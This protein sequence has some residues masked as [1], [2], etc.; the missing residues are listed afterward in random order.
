MGKNKLR[1][2]LWAA[3]ATFLVWDLSQWGT[4]E[5]PIRHAGVDFLGYFASAR[6]L[7]GGGNPYDPAVMLRAE[8][9]LGYSDAKALV[10]WAPPWS[11]LLLLPFTLFPFEAARVAWFCCNAALL[12]WVAWQYWKIVSPIRPGWWVALPVFL[13]V[14]SALALNIGQVSPVVLV[15]LFGFARCAESRRDFL[16]GVF[17]VLPTI[18]PHPVYLF[19][20]FLPFWIAATRRWRVLSGLAI[21]LAASILVVTFLSPGVFV[22]YI[23]GIASEYGAKAWETPTIPTL[24]RVAFPR[25]GEILMYVPAAAG[26]ALGLVVW[27]RRRA[28]FQW[29]DAMIPVT[30][31]STITAPYGWTMDLVVLLP[32]VLVILAK[33]AASPRCLWLPFSALAAMQIVMLVQIYTAQSY[34]S[35]VWVAPAMAAVYWLATRTR[36]SRTAAA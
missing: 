5:K 29:L 12:V 25:G 19:W 33:F 1:I 4:A 16:A 14:P 15:G 17:A 31:L 22:A 18:K 21:P 35:L 11:H 34:F 28:D 3:I 30:L 24:L 8:R 23:E 32:V 2:L 13:F 26:C 7:A 27:F 9:E 10:V 20:L 6:T 36:V